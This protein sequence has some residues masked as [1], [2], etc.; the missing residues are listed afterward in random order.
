MATEIER[1]YLVNN[2]WQDV[3]PDDMIKITQGYLA[4]AEDTTVRIRMMDRKGTLEAR[5]AVK[6]PTV[7][8]SRP[9]FEYAI[10]LSDAQEMLYLCGSR[11]VWKIRFFV[12]SSRKGLVWEIDVFKGKHEGLVLAEIE[13]VSPEDRMV[14]LPKW[15]DREVSGDCRYSNHSLAIHGLKLVGK[16]A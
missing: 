11:I 4:T 8:I 16:E 14:R 5:L 13:L 3:V 9:E 2:R 15:I 12:P 6:G 10:P 1:K 7:G